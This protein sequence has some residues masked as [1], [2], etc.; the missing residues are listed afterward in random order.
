MSY[1]I[2]G[3]CISCGSCSVI[4]PQQAVGDGYTGPALISSVWQGYHI[5]GACNGC[6]SCVQVCPVEAIVRS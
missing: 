2:T 3:D 6:G 5:T 4:C 1:R